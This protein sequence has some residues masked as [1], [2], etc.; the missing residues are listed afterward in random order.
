MTD[1]AH[2]LAGHPPPGVAERMARLRALCIPERD[3]EARRRLTNRPQ[4]TNAPFAAAV[5]R[6][7]AE[8]SS[9]CDLANYLR[10]R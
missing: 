10:R 1:A 9:L 5:A 7:L 4:A 2:R 3:A 8:L 6:R